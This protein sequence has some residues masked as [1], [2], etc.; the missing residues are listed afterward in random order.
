MSAAEQF[1]DA[2]ASAGFNIPDQNVFC[3]FASKV[4]KSGDCWVWTAAKFKSG[5]GRFAIGATRAQREME[6]AHR[7]AYRLFVGPIPKGM[8]VCH[9]CDVRGCV[10]PEHL[11]LGTQKD[12]VHDCIAKGRA[13]KHTGPNPKISGEGHGNHKLTE[14][15]VREILTSA[16]SNVALGAKFSVHYRTIWLIRARK[17]WAHITVEA[18]P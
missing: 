11:F 5:Y 10:N 2:I 17:R 13:R 16:D 18:Q 9:Q 3:R 14:A 15:N 7:A 1:R 6:Y 8:V 12:N 4:V